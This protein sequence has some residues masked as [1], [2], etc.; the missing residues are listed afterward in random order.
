MLRCV[1]WCSILVHF[2]GLVS[3]AALCS[4][5]QCVALH[6][7]VSDSVVLIAASKRAFNLHW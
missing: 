6:F 5:M 4:V 7:I 2:M 3:I 1:I